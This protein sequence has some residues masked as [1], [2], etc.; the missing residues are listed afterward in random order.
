MSSTTYPV[1]IQRWLWQ[2]F[3]TVLDNETDYDRYNDRLVEAI[4]ADVI[5]FDDEGLTDLDAGD[6]QRIE[7][8]LDDVGSDDAAVP[9]LL[10]A[11][12]GQDH[13]GGRDSNAQPR[14]ERRR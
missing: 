8:L 6:R 11:D 10:T 14:G 4:A 5:R 3:T 13:G 9:S 7:H 2:H 1:D 12:T